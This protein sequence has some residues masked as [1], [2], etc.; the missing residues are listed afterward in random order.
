VVSDYSFACSHY[1]AK[2]TLS[3]WLCRH[4]IPG[5]YGVDT[6]A[7][8]KVIRNHGSM[9]GRVL[10]SGDALAKDLPFDDP[11]L[12]NLAASVSRTEIENFTPSLR[13]VRATLE[14]TG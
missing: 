1:T 14:S 13:R 5:I 3:Q 4:G 7:I 9:L 8:T 6:R 10:M 11:N 12:R 2:Q